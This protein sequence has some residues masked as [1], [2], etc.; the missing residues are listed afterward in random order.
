MSPKA[1][2]TTCELASLAQFKVDS[3]RLDT[4][5]EQEAQA[6]DEEEV[7]EDIA[8]EIARN[9]AVQV[10]LAEAVATTKQEDNKDFSLLYEEALKL[11]EGSITAG[12]LRSYQ[13]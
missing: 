10:E 9:R 7:A 1:T 8:E 2:I 11:S 13:K 4:I 12:T 6:G 5:N 3:V